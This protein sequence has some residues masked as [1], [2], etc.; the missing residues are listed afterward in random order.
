MSWSEIKSALNSTLGTKKYKP[1]NEII[2]DKV[3]VP[4]DNIFMIPIAYETNVRIVIP[5]KFGGAVKV[6][7]KYV[8]PKVTDSINISIGGIY[9]RR[10][11]YGT[12]LN[13]E[14]SKEF[15]VYVQSGDSLQ[16]ITS[17]GAKIKSLVICA[18]LVT[19]VDD[20]PTNIITPHADFRR[21][22]DGLCQ[23]LKVRSMDVDE[24]DEF[25]KFMVFNGEI[26]GHPITE[27]GERAI[28]QESEIDSVYVKRGIKNIVTRSIL[29]SSIVDLYLPST[30]ESIAIDAFEGSY[31]EN[32]Y[33]PWREG[34]IPG[35]P[36]GAEIDTI[37]Y[38]DDFE[39]YY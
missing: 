36:W 30:I 13:Q 15:D 6:K 31:I 39:T 4:S 33:V 17:G 26:Y 32:L 3:F 2:E 23:V 7:I 16:V 29:D 5:L 12:S 34:Q 18:D 21:R 37:E 28:Y 35:A 11:T 14:T 19:K 25:S 8:C 10:C 20:M 38:E 24:K 9:W 22:S 1:L 27:T